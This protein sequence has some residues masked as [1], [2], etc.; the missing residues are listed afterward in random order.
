MVGSRS[1]GLRRRHAVMPPSKLKG[2]TEAVAAHAAVDLK[3]AEAVEK[4][5]TV[6]ARMVG[7]SW[8]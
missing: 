6:E 7:R 2:S 5:R 4:Y 3:W 1:F 8:E